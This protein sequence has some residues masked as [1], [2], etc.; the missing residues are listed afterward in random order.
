ME[1]FGEK[2]YANLMDSIEKSRTTLLSRV[3]Y[4]LGIPN[5]GVANAKLLCRFFD[6][7]FAKLRE[8][9]EEEIASVEGIGPIIAASVAGYFADAA[10]ASAV[11]ELLAELTIERPQA[12]RQAKTFIGKTFVITGSVEHFANRSELK[13][14][15]EERGGKVTGSVTKKTD[16]LINNDTTSASSKNKKAQ[17]LGIPVISEA[18]FLELEVK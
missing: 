18:E 2:S 16:Y 1:G 7:D 14:Y 5:I 10:N 3:V 9:G 12:N 8:A 6:Y 13:S 15:I 11:D 4:A 17:E